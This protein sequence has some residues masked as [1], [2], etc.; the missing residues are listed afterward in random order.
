[1]Y[2]TLRHA[3]VARFFN[4]SSRRRSSRKGLP[5]SRGFCSRSA[6]TI[7]HRCGGTRC[8]RTLTRGSCGCKGSG[9]L[10]NVVLL[11][12]AAPI[13]SSATL[14]R[15]LVSYRPLALG[16]GAC[17]EAVTRTKLASGTGEELR[18]NRDS[19]GHINSS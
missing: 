12:R 19:E 1:M 15:L 4:A 17:I 3:S 7:R 9:V 6:A 14:G 13:V 16:P 11:T 5:I 10:C 8:S 18:F 2:A